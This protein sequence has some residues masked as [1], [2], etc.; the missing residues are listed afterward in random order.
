MNPKIDMWHQRRSC[1]FYILWP[2]SAPY[3]LDPNMSTG[4]VILWNKK[5][6]THGNQ[7][8]RKL[9]AIIAWS[10]K[11]IFTRMDRFI[12]MLA[13]ILITVVWKCVCISDCFVNKFNGFRSE[14][15][16][17]SNWT[18][19]Y[20]RY[21]PLTSCRYISKIGQVWSLQKFLT[22]ALSCKSMGI[23]IVLAYSLTCT[24]IR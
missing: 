6:E 12:L 4:S 14:M 13:L 19:N 7:C 15:F 22:F 1:R 23:S 20:C 8:K 2:K 17:S 16:W 24:L 18:L 9:W 21:G 5:C 10:G 3:P 11:K